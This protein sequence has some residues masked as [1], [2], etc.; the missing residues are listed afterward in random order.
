MLS[1]VCGGFL[2]LVKVLLQVCS[3]SPT[4]FNGRYKNAAARRRPSM[5]VANVQ[6]LTDARRNAV[7]K[8]RSSPTPVEMLSQN[9]GAHRR[10]SKCRRKLQELIDARRN[11]AANCRSSLKPVD[12]RCKNAAAR[13]RPSAV[14]QKCR[15]GAGISFLG[16]TLF[17]EHEVDGQ[18]QAA[19]S[20]QVVPVERLAPEEHRGED[21]EDDERDDLLDDLELHER[22]RSAVARESDAVG[23][24]LTGIFGQGNEPREQDDAEERPVGDDLHFLKFQMP[25]PG[26]GHEDVGY[27]EQ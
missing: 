4:P 9:A 13:R 16:G 21:G 14:L 23:R 12:G 24:N 8:C 10:P 3:S 17:H 15:R 11:A 18:N 1:Q 26:E 27:H 5:A 2:K 6:Q 19:E 22:E 25:V 7:A 20:G